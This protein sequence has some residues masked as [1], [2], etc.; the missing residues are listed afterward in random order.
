M[1]TSLIEVAKLHQICNLTEIVS[2]VLIRL[3]FVVERL[4]LRK[5]QASFGEAFTTFAFEFRVDVRDVI[6]VVPTEIVDATTH[7]TVAEHY[8]GTDGSGLNWLL[9]RICEHYS[10][11][12]DCCN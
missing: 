10:S 12:N 2:Y 3:P 4:V 8:C 9:V 6:Y 7:G 5:E 11:K 1:K